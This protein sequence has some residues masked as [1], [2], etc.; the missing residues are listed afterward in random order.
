MIKLKCRSAIQEIVMLPKIVLKSYANENPMDILCTFSACIGVEGRMDKKVSAKFSVI[1]GTELA[2]LGYQTSC[3]LNILRVGP[4]G[5][6]NWT[7]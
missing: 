6:V 2:L 4:P 7:E 1:K 3:E 5:T